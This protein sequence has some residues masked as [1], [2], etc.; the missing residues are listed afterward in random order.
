MVFV[1]QQTIQKSRVL[2]R[3]E[4]LRW[5]MLQIQYLIEE[6]KN[7]VKVQNELLDV[8]LAL[9]GSRNLLGKFQ[10]VKIQKRAF[11]EIQVQIGSL[12]S[13]NQALPLAEVIH[14]EELLEKL[15]AR[16]AEFLL[17]QSQLYRYL[18]QEILR[19]LEVQR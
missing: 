2:D 18:N 11:D 9:K 15:H 4:A 16:A 5:K 13:K 3:G 8:E 12:D 14:F 6:Q 1:I 10:F 19:I 17:A 7:I